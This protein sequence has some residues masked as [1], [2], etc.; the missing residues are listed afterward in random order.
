[1]NNSNIFAYKKYLSIGCLLICSTI[2]FACNLFPSRR[3]QKKID[4]VSMEYYLPRLMDRAKQWQDD[5][6]L[7]SVFMPLL[8]DEGFKPD[9]LIYADFMSDSRNDEGLAI[10]LTLN[11]RIKTEKVEFNKPQAPKRPLTKQVWIYDSQKALNMILDD[12]NVQKDLRRK[13]AFSLTLDHYSNIDQ[14]PIWSLTLD[15]GNFNGSIYYFLD[16]ADG[17]VQELIR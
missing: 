4:V 9:W 17:T 8:H 2:F 6:Y 15:D 5:A 13:G 16:P 3:P 10:T 12:E 11:E 14:R 7:V 1:M